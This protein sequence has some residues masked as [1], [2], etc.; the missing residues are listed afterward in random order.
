MKQ[1]F[2]FINKKLITYPYTS[3]YRSFNLDTIGRAYCRLKKKPIPF[4]P[5]TKFGK[6]NVKK[7]T[8][9]NCTPTR[10]SQI[11]EPILR[12]SWFGH[13]KNF[14]TL[15]VRP[16]TSTPWLNAAFGQVRPRLSSLTR[17]LHM[18]R[19]IISPTH[20]QATTLRAWIIIKICKQRR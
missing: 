3:F 15:P 18:K 1:V 11:Y 6:I 7:I 17:L 12:S 5:I 4:Y 9:G 8:R 13:I 16:L 19:G 2:N 20:L 14:S 10:K